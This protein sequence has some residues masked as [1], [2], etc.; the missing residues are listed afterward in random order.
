MRRA[1]NDSDKMRLSIYE[2]KQQ[3][4][5]EIEQLRRQVDQLQGGSRENFRDYVQLKR[6]LNVTKD[7]NDDLKTRLKQQES[8]N[9]GLPALKGPSSISGRQ[10]SGR[11]KSREMF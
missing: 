2:Q 4:D 9:G 1:L 11:R 6:Q 5:Q 7:Q 3:A 8:R 10:P